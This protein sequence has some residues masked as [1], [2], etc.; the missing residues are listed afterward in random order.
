VLSPNGVDNHID[1]TTLMKPLIEN[2]TDG[3]IEFNISYTTTALQYIFSVTQSSSRLFGVRIQGGKI[4]VLNSI[5]GTNNIIETDNT[6]NDGLFH[7]VIVGTNTGAYTISVDGVNQP[8]TA[9]LG[10]NTSVWFNDIIINYIR[11]FNVYTTSE[12]LF[13]G[14]L[15]SSLI[16]DGVNIPFQLGSGN[17]VYNV[18][19]LYPANKYTIE[20]TV[21]ASSWANADVEKDY[22]LDEGFS[23]YSDVELVTNGDFDSSDNWTTLSPWSISGGELSTDASSYNNTYQIGVFEM[24]KPYRII[25]KSTG[26]TCRVYLGGSS[27]TAYLFNAG[28]SVIE[29]IA[30]ATQLTFRNLTT[31]VQIQS[32]EVYSFDKLPASQVNSGLDVLGNALTNPAVYGG[33]KL[34][35]RNGACLM[36]QQSNDKVLRDADTDNVWFEADGTRKQLT[37]QEMLFNTGNYD[38]NHIIDP[39]KNVQKHLLYG[40]AQS[41]ENQEKIVKCQ[42]KNVDNPAQFN[43]GNI[44]QF[45]NGVIAQ[46]NN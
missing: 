19:A 6:F 39:D 11:I 38:Y 35:G 43:D 14:G 32:V 24:G 8:L 46:F 25:I 10:T 15:I 40:A 16:V 4:K 33:D 18:N 26:G 23:D 9:S 1:A 22:N 17:K 44:A 12:A 27:T 2:D 34:I 42:A 45:N 31:A 21:N 41:S 30:A 13:F 5:S 36:Q 28:T 3:T 7:K 29:G 20:G 37:I